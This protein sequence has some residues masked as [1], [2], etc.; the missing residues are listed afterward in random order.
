MIGE[1]W[2]VFVGKRDE[3]SQQG[4][5]TRISCKNESGATQRHDL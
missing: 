2:T 3:F 4:W 1:N 5:K